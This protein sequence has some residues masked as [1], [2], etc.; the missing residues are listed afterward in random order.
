MRRNLKIKSIFIFLAWAMIFVHGIIPHNHIDADVRECPGYVHN[1][2]ESNQST[3]Y[4][5]LC[6]DFESCGLSNIL[7]QKFS[8]DDN[9]L[10]TERQTAPD[11][12]IIAESYVIA[13]DQDIPSGIHP[14]SVLL[15]APPVA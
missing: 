15:R 2:H 5:E 13:H 14:Y 3:E 10:I 1:H 7:F 12:Y 8:S 4:R 6:K 9:P 11:L